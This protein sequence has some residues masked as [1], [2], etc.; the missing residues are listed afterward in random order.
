MSN[1][2]DELKK[3]AIV[4]IPFIA[5]IVITAIILTPF[6]WPVGFLIWIV[7]VMGMLLLLVRWHAR[8]TIYHCPNCGNNFE[9]SAFE[10]LVSPHGTAN[11]SW[12]YLRCPRCQRMIKASE[13]TRKEMDKQDAMHP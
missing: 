12:T 11:G 10:D 6:S 13:A 9:I 2:R 3:S 1:G 5:T 8:N 7:L 4:L